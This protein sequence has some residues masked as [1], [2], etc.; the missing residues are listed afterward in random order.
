MPDTLPLSKYK[1]QKSVIGGEFANFLWRIVPEWISP[2]WLEAKRWR[3]FVQNQPLAVV[4]RDT[5]IANILSLDWKIVP[6]ES[7]QL[8]EEK[9]NIKAYTKILENS[10]TF[11]SDLDFSGHVEWVAKDMLDLPFGGASEIGREGDEPNG[12]VLW[13]RP[14]DGGTLAPTLNRDYPVMQRVP[15]Y[16]TTPVFFPYYT[17]SRAYLSPRT[18][19]KREGWG[20]APPEKIYLALELLYR[21]DNYYANLLLNTPEVGILDLGD[22]EKESAEN[23]I[24]SFRDLMYGT[25]AFKVP[26]LYEHTTPVNWLPFGKLPNDI[27]FDKLI[28]HYASLVAA[29]YGMSVSDLGISTS[30]NGGETLSGT[31]RQERRTQR[32]GLS[33]LKKKLTAYFNAILPEQLKFVWIDYDD[34]RQVSLSRARLAS[35]NAWSLLIDKRVFSPYE[36]RLQT[37]Q[38]GL[39]TVSV[40]ENVPADSEF[41]QITALPTGANSLNNN[42]QK[43]SLGGQGD[44]SAQQI[45]QRSIDVMADETEKLLEIPSVSE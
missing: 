6:R 35:A 23:W 27:M 43:P 41:P 37:I 42:A 34:E 45:V 10:S 32:T 4:A 20:M 16:P 13:I 30:S 36:V 2:S 38:D 31:I 25:N 40:P 26:V 29:G 18:E 39:I 14:L 24:N 22:M 5:L 44:V 9:E 15:E 12:E 3:S 21:G 8:E 33:T 17:V 7:E 1:G 28:M 11:Y 19:I